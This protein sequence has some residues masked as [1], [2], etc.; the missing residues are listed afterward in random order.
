MDQQRPRPTY[1]PVAPGSRGRRG[2]ETAPTRRLA[3]LLRRYRA[4]RD[5]DP[6]PA[7]R[8]YAAEVVRELRNELNARRPVAAEGR[9]A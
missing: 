1:L 8:Q 9:A 4:M 6:N 7:A 3:D 5:T 2:F